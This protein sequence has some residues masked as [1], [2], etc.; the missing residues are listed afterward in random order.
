VLS[1]NQKMLIETKVE[2]I[3]HGLMTG[4][5]LHL[6]NMNRH[7]IPLRDIVTHYS[8]FAYIANLTIWEP[9]DVIP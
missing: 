6:G 9:M 2:R 7:S 5:S 3:A 4:D 1:I 8:D